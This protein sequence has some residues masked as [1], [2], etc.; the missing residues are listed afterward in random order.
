MKKTSNPAPR[1]C[2]RVRV[3]AFRAQLGYTFGALIECETRTGRDHTAT[4]ARWIA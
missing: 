3:Y 2:D 4:I 1:D